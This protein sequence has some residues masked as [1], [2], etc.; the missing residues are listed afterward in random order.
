MPLMRGKLSSIS[1]Q[2]APTPNCFQDS[3]TV[4]Q[5]AHSGSHWRVWGRIPAA[6]EN[7]HTSSLNTIA[8]ILER[9][10]VTIDVT[11]NAKLSYAYRDET[12]ESCAHREHP[13]KR[14][15]MKVTCRNSQMLDV[16]LDQD[17][18][19]S[20]EQN[21]TLIEFIYDHS[22]RSHATEVINLFH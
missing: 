2:L 20:A 22:A 18:R 12:N 10:W 9:T 4:E 7:H 3:E 8:P 5:L 13:R 14:L 19:P 15:K 16:Q 17:L 21:V 1:S 11:Y 6:K